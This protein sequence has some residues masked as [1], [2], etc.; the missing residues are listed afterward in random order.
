MRQF[1]GE[2]EGYILI[3]KVKRDAENAAHLLEIDRMIPIHNSNGKQRYPVKYMWD[4]RHF[5]MKKTQCSLSKG[6][7]ENFIIILK[8]GEISVYDSGSKL[9]KAG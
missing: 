5:T 3:W 1:S 4:V 9:I 8:N 7:G 2:G 6:L